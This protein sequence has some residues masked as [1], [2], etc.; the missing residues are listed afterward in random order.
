M[1]KKVIEFYKNNLEKNKANLLIKG[2]RKSSRE[3]A[4][5]CRNER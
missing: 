3:F 2:E 1:N 4:K 5:K